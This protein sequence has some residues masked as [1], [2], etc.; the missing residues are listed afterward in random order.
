MTPPATVVGVPLTAREAAVRALE[1]HAPHLQ[2]GDVTPLGSGVDHTAF[3]CGD[4]VVRVAGARSARRE[5]QPLTVLGP[6]SSVPV[7]APLLAD[8][9][10]GVLAHP[11]LLGRPLLGRT[12]P[13]GAAGRLGAFLTELHSVEPSA[14]ADL[15]E[16]EPADPRE[17]L[18]DLSGPEQLLA[19]VHAQVPAPGDRHVLAHADLGAEHLLE[20]GGALTGVLDWSDAAVTDPAVDFARLYRDF[21][22]RFLREVL[23]AYRLPPPGAAAVARTESSARCAALEDL[24]FAGASGRREHADAVRT[25]AE[26]LCPGSRLDR[27]RLACGSTTPADSGRPP[28]PGPAARRRWRDGV[29]LR[30]LRTVAAQRNRTRRHLRCAAVCA[31]GAGVGRPGTS[32]ASEGQWPRQQAGWGGDLVLRGC[33]PAGAPRL[34]Q[35]PPVRTRCGLDGGG[36]AAG[37]AQRVPVRRPGAHQRRGT[38]VDGRQCLPRSGAGL[39]AGYLVLVNAVVVAVVEGR[40]HRRGTV[41]GQAR[42]PGR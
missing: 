9:E 28:D 17:W 36:D 12:P 6:R 3:R 7:P 41:A 23:D 19:V 33:R 38:G 1:V 5:A 16:E 25:S 26:R 42:A 10:L 29:G 8:E 24:A 14:V 34:Q 27:R 30:C 32:G 40:Q 13:A 21:G 31:A 4:V 22:P 35:L 11:L 20:D 37:C 15:V 2:Q 39:A 18:A